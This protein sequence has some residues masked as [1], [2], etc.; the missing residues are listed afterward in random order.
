MS[1]TNIFSFFSTTALVLALAGSAGATT[2]TIGGT[3]VAGQGLMSSQAGA[4][5]T[6]FNGLTSLPAGFTAIGTT[7]TN[8]VVSGSQSNVYLAPTG[9]TSTYLS[10]G[11]GSITD[12]LKGS[13][14]FGFDWGSVDNYNTLA[15]ADSSGNVTYYTGGGLGV[16]VN[17]NNSYFVNFY[18]TPGTTFTQA[19]FSSSTNSFEIDN[20]A[21]AT[22]EPSTVAMLAGGLLV[23][24]G[25]LR[26]RKA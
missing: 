1:K 2:F 22:P 9:D 7:P 19:T 23:V 3:A 11:T 15:L 5:T 26:R 12:T 6:T 18:S 10:V 14:Y 8:P 24:A 16:L 4:A 21:S 25:A 20:V 13:T 17:G